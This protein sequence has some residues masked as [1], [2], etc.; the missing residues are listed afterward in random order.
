VILRT[1]I[2]SYSIFPVTVK[3]QVFTLFY[4]ALNKCC[5]AWL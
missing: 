1:V 5:S 2:I 4:S 3:M